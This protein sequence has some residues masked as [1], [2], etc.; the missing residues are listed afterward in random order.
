MHE[1]S[2]TGQQCEKLKYRIGSRKT[3]DGSVTSR[4]TLIR[5][6]ATGGPSGSCPLPNLFSVPQ[7]KQM[8]F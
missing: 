4:Q 2:D 1:A 8:P 5:H 6:V 7:N 3:D